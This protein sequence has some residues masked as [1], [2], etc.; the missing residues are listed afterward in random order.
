[1]STDED[2]ARPEAAPVPPDDKGRRG[3]VRAP[4]A[5]AALVAAAIYGLL[6]DTLIIGPRLVV[7][8]LE[9]TLI[10]AV[11]VTNPHRSDR[12]SRRSRGLSLILIL[13]IALT[14]LVSLVLL[15]G[16]LVASSTSHG[17]L[18]LLAA[19]QVWVTNVI[20]FAAAYWELDRGGPVARTRT[21]RRHLAAADFRFTQDE[22][23]DTA[24]EVAAGSSQANDWVP[25]FIDYLYVS[26][27]NS[28]AFSP[29]DTM[30]LSPRAKLLMGVEA[31]AA[32]VTSV[33]VIAKGVS[34]LGK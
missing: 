16:Q 22:D 13:M 15:V 5:G 21:D 11:M 33:L 12:H 25:S 28:S 34:G 24:P 31:T 27:T 9:L 20:V 7:P 18:L 14:N 19:G 8:C 32:L 3:L 10:V 1:V 2:R 17:R 29:T 6:P 26:L 30:P 4:A 23:A